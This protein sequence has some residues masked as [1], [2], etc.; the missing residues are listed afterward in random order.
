M[1]RKMNYLSKYF[2]AMDT[3]VKMQLISSLK[4]VRGTK[5]GVLTVLADVPEGRFVSPEE[6]DALRD[7]FLHRQA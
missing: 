5:T 3:G 4:K 7:R 6:N 2:L 1:V